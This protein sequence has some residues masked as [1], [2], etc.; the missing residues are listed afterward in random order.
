[1]T[2]SG[3]GFNASSVVKFNGLTASAVTLVP[4]RG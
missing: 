2:I 1:V 4:R 3:V